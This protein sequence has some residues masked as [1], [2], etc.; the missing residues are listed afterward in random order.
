M[1]FS[2]YQAQPDGSLITVG[3]VEDTIT[4]AF[5]AK[6]FTFVVL[7]NEVVVRIGLNSADR[8]GSTWIVL[9]PGVHHL[10]IQ[11]AEI[12]YK[13]LTAGSAARLQVVAYA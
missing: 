6:G 10:S 11:G 1:S 12:G 2:I 7:D 9:P 4:F 5:I 8:A 3:D 13:N